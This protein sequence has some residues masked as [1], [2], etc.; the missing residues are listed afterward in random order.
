MGPSDALFLPAAWLHE[1]HGL[2]PSITLS[3]LAIPWPNHVHV[4]GPTGA[5]DV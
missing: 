4:L 2:E 1:V 3:W 5:D